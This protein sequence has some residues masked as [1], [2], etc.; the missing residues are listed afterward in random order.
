[1]AQSER[2]TAR[3]TKDEIWD[4][5]R[6]H[7]EVEDRLLL[8]RYDKKGR[9]NALREELLASSFANR[10]QKTQRRRSSRAL[11][12]QTENLR[13]FKRFVDGFNR[14]S[15]SA[16][17]RTW[18]ELTLDE[19]RAEECIPPRLRCV[20]PFFD[21]AM[22]DALGQLAKTRAIA[23]VSPV[24]GPRS[25][26]ASHHAHR[27][28][29]TKGPCWK[30]AEVLELVRAWGTVV[31]NADIAVASFTDSHL[32]QWV[33]WYAP[34]THSQV[35]SWRKMSSL[36]ASYR[37]ISAFNHRC[38]PRQWFK[39]PE[40]ERDR[41]TDW[42]TLPPNFEN[43]DG[44]IFDEMERIEVKTKKRLSTPPDAPSKCKIKVQ[45]VSWSSEPADSV[46]GGV[47]L[48]SRTASSV[49][50]SPQ[51]RRSTGLSGH[52][53]TIAL[54]AEGS[55]HGGLVDMA[56]QMPWLDSSGTTMPGNCTQDRGASEDS[57]HPPP[58]SVH[59]DCLVVFSR[60]L[61][62]HNTE[63]ARAMNELKASLKET[64]NESEEL[65]LG[66]TRECFPAGSGD[67]AFVSRLLAQQHQRIEHELAA[68]EKQR[69]HRATET[70]TI[71]S[72]LLAASRKD[73][74]CEMQ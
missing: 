22:C 60:I 8:T 12:R 74:D 28:H 67:A 58:A 49:R 72:K 23:S 9:P 2:D 55:D 7:Q 16:G 68:F 61:D 70:H 57:C 63:A 3:W 46:G 30:E 43:I 51:L 56:E 64:C 1:M 10:G 66:V 34:L 27:C 31:D 69:Y 47:A 45:Q 19:Q 17:R 65:V 32:R 4:L 73:A 38:A 48:V 25:S 20:Q 18:F 62:A 21:Q 53:D 44:K 29:P 42:D 26:L 52:T 35:V 37:F 6:S 54:V 71:L 15:V 40:S 50:A 24:H 14:S 41:W 36:I 11:C 59:R 13:A 39:L 5:I 33:D